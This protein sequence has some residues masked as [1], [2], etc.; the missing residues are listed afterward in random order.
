MPSATHEIS[1]NKPT[2]GNK[3]HPHIIA[4][5]ASYKVFPPFSQKDRSN[6]TEY[7]RFTL[8]CYCEMKNLFLSTQTDNFYL[9]LLYLFCISFLKLSIQSLGQQGLVWKKFFM[10][11]QPTSTC[12]FALKY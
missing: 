7:I 8:V 3:K 11:Y 5:H 10:R 4:Q 6:I 9:G 1:S 2:A 12:L